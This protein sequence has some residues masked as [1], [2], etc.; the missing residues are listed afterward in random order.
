MDQN[1]NK[2]IIFGELKK[3]EYE[4]INE[5]LIEANIKVI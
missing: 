2:L 5:R 4:E 3:N 1:I